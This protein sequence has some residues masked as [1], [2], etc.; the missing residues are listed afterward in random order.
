MSFTQCH[1]ISPCFSTRVI[2]ETFDS[3]FRI[4]NIKLKISNILAFLKGYS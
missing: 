4:S 1:S 3:I 2:L